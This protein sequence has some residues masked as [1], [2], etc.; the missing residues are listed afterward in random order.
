MP[1]A[2]NVRPANSGA[3]FRMPTAP[4]Q[5]ILP[6]P[7]AR[8][9]PQAS[10]QPRFSSD[11]DGSGNDDDEAGSSGSSAESDSDEYRIMSNEDRL[12]PPSA[13]PPRQPRYDPRPPP[14]TSAP[15]GAPPPETYPQP[16]PYA[17]D[18][19]APPPPSPA[20]APTSTPQSELFDYRRERDELL[21][22]IG[23]L[24]ERG[25]KASRRISAETPIT[26]LR[27]EYDRMQM[28]QSLKLSIKGQRRALMG[29]VSLIEWANNKSPFKLRL[30]GLSESIL[31]TVEDYDG[32]FENL[33]HK[34]SSSVSMSPEMQL[35]VS[36]SG[37]IFMFHLSSSMINSILPS[38]QQVVN[39]NPNLVQNVLTSMQSAMSPVVTTPAGGQPPSGGGASPGSPPPG[40]AAPQSPFF[41][42]PPAF[43]TFF[44]Q[45]PPPPPEDSSSPG[46][47]ASSDAGSVVSIN[48]RRRGGREEAEMQIA[49]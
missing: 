26:D 14:P 12:A 41:T 30:D 31:D 36:L 43:T 38:V 20:P 48:R 1:P 15:Y 18:L 28:S 9:A 4:R 3:T 46:G 10:R 27:A 24:E 37:A 22:K 19:Y 6:S 47:D 13:P 17:E 34:Y 8:F 16:Q 39:A 2:F 33:H 49:L 23:R 32:I 44:E 45:P 29:F 11:D 7:R 25:F 40:T 5:S 42:P 35:L 21:L